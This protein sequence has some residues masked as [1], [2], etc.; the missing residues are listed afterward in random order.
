MASEASGFH[1]RLPHTPA[2]QQ[3]KRKDQTSNQLYTNML[4]AVRAQVVCVLRKCV[5]TPKANANTPC[6]VVQTK[7][8]VIT[9]LFQ[10]LKLLS[11]NVTVNKL[12]TYTTDTFH[13]LWYLFRDYLQSGYRHLSCHTLTFKLLLC[14][15]DLANADTHV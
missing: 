14:W 3:V 15:R 5:Q 13:S 2:K 11:G 9:P 7:G 6:H 12:S 10:Y 8:V 4:Q 1:M